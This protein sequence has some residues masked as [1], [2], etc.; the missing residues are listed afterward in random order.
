[1]QGTLLGGVEG[2]AWLVLVAGLVTQAQQ[3]FKNVGG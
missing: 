2:L 3:L 1:M